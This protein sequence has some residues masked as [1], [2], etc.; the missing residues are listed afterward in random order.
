MEP[1]EQTTNKR[2]NVKVLT[3]HNVR[4][5]G[6]ETADIVVREVFLCEL[7][8]QHAVAR[9]ARLTGSPGEG[10]ARRR[11]KGLAKAGNSQ[12]RRGSRRGESGLL[13]PT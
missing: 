4:C 13:N 2:P 9:Y 7:R 5:I 3:A 12:A 8:D 1:L 11:E 6:V 10:G